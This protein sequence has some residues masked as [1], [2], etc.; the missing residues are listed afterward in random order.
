MTLKDISSGPDWVIWGVFGIFVIMSIV[1]LTGHGANLIAGYNTSSEKEKAK[2]N[3]KKLCRVVGICFSVIT[4]MIGVMAV[5][6][7]VLPAAFS[8][9]FLIVTVIDCITVL[10]LMNTICRR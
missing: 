4:M 3:K 1:L 2:Y 7:S 5:G 10:I 8:T 9:V 6:E